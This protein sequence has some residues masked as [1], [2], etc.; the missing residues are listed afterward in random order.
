MIYFAMHD[1]ADHAQS[2]MHVK[3]YFLT[4][5]SYAYLFCSIQVTKMNISGKLSACYSRL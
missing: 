3:A 4:L 2:I 1:D 5:I